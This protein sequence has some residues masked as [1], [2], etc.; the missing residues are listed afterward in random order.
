M[1]AGLQ[2]CQA[3]AQRQCVNVSA[4]QLPE[5]AHLTPGPL[6]ATQPGLA[7]LTTFCSSDSGYASLCSLAGCETGLCFQALNAS[8]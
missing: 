1:Q 4:H 8:P 3:G 7:S 6:L 2:Q 5:M